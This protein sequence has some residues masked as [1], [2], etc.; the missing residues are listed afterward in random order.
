MTCQESL[1]MST[2]KKPNNLSEE[3]EITA[4]E[5]QDFGDLL[6]LIEQ[7]RQRVFSQLNTALT[8]LY[9]DFVQSEKFM[10]LTHTISA[11]AAPRAS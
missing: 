7:M 8:E 6:Q 1:R 9:W 3:L 2:E 10:N 5:R 4:N 11:T